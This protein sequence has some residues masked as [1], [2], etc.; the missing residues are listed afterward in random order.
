[1]PDSATLL[2]V[3]DPMCSWCWGFA[4]TIAELK[5]RYPVQIVL[6]GLAPDSSEPMASEMRAYVQ[7]A[8]HDVAASTGA[9]FNFDFWAQCT[10][11]RSTYPANRAMILARRQG[12]EWQML[13]AIQHGYYLH[14]QNPSDAS[15]LADL[16]GAIG[17]DR[18]L[19]LDQLNAD[20]T[21]SALER[22]FE[23]RRGIGANSFPSIGLRETST[24][25]DDF[26]LIHSG[27]VTLD[28]IRV[29]LEPWNKNQVSPGA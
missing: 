19:F 23:L 16:A 10:P 4:P 11:R 27:W 12:W 13:E 14:A 20:A 3:V 26:Q 5:K 2:Y 17:M 28:Q 29:K 22:D 6:G 15:V 25:G 18:S 7:Q 21:Q 1:M 9:K 8:W 24:S